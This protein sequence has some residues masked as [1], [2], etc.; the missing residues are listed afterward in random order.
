MLFR[1][2]KSG[3]N[4]DRSVYESSPEKHVGLLRY[5]LTLPIKATYPQIQHYLAEVI[6]TNSN[7]ALESI[8]FK[9]ESLDSPMVDANIGLVVYVR[10]Q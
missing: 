1:S 9:R 3:L 7:L 5:Q 8:N 6:Q 10:A 2:E 4:I